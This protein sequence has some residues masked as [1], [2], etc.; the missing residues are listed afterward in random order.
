MHD[1]SSF[2]SSFFSTVGLFHRLISRIAQ[3]VGS[4]AELYYR[5]I[6]FPV[7]RNHW[8]LVEMKPHPDA[9]IKVEISILKKTNYYSSLPL[10][11]DCIIFNE[12]V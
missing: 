5:Q 11:I 8:V 2:F 3:L 6:Y 4:K 12:M 10:V 9:V 7:A 1:L